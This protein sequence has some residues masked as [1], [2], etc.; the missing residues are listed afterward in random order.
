MDGDNDKN[1]EG[2]KRGS[3]GRPYRGKGGSGGRPY[4][5]KG[6]SGGRG[7]QVGGEVVRKRKEDSRGKKEDGRKEASKERRAGGREGRG[8]YLLILDGVQEALILALF[9]AGQRLSPSHEGGLEVRRGQLLHQLL[10]VCKMERKSGEGRRDKRGKGREGTL[11]RNS[12][13]LE[14][15]QHHQNQ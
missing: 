15:S 13:S 4:R 9:E 10:C 11:V 6:G 1:D 8:A 7:R 3:G 5:G 12:T 2:R 14:G